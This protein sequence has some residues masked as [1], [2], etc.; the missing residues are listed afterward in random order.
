MIL[1]RIWWEGI[2]VAYLVSW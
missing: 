1:D 2:H